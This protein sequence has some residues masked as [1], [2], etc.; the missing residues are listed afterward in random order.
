MDTAHYKCMTQADWVAVQQERL[1]L[2]MPL[3]VHWDSLDSRMLSRFF[4][5]HPGRKPGL[6][7]CAPARPAPRMLSA[8]CH[9]HCCGTMSCA[10]R[11]LA[12]RRRRTSCIVHKPCKRGCL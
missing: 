11:G 8:S 4:E 12:V 1:M 10:L 3:D 2:D 9:A 7:Q 6:Y 5:R